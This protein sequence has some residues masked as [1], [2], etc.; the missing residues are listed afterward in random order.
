MNTVT[1]AVEAAE[2]IESV[3]DRLHEARNLIRLGSP[4]GGPVEQDAEAILTGADAILVITL[5]DLSTTR[6]SLLEVKSKSEVGS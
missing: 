4:S 1:D 6:G 3:I 5:D 2:R